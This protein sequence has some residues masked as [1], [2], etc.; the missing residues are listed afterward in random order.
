MNYGVYLASWYC[1]IS[2]L[3]LPFLLLCYYSLLLC[4]HATVDHHWQRHHWKNQ[5]EPAI[6]LQAASHSGLDAYVLLM[7]RIGCCMH[8][9]SILPGAP[10]NVYKNRWKGRS[11]QQILFFC[12]RVCCMSL[13]SKVQKLAGRGASLKKGCTT[14]TLSDWSPLS[15]TNRSTF[16]RRWDCKL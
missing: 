7:C 11:M 14:L 16:T 2:S 4:R 3:L 13:T 6:S 8:A 15:L 1:F 10:H 9:E 12:A 5:F